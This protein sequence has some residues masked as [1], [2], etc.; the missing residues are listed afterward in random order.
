LKTIALLY[1]TFTDNSALINEIRER[2]H[3]FSDVVVIGEHR[4]NAD[5]WE[6]MEKEA[7][8]HRDDYVFVM[9]DTDYIDDVSSLQRWLMLNSE[10][11]Y[12][13]MRLNMYTGHEYRVDAGYKPRLMYQLFPYKPNATLH[14]EGLPTY[15]YSLPYINDPHLTVLSFRNYGEQNKTL[16]KVTTKEWDNPIPTTASQG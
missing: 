3:S 12:A 1:P 9:E 7:E 8:P 16:K 4:S 14:K 11:A 5:N 6:Q 10:S 13:C 2:A 15:S